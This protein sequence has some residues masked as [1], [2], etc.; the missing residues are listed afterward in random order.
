MKMNFYKIPGSLSQQMSNLRRKWGKSRWIEG[1]GEDA[2][3]GRTMKDRRREGIELDPTARNIGR[4][5]WRWERSR[6]GK[7]PATR[8][9]TETHT[10]STAASI[11]IAKAEISKRASCCY[12]R[13]VAISYSSI[14]TS[15]TAIRPMTSLLALFLKPI[16]LKNH[17]L[18][19]PT[20]FLYS[21]ELSE[22]NYYIPVA[23]CYQSD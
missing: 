13:K 8:C 6:R 7:W 16:P 1:W 22:F 17:W 10:T 3:A 15:S 14:R 5:I 2:Y 11:A 19:Q 12:I 21:A 4:G 20:L 9:S 23:A 18:L